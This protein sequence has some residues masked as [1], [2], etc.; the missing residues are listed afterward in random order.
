MEIIEYGGW[1]RNVRM[2]N[3]KIEL[4]ATLD[5][6]PRI[7][8]LAV[9]GGPNVFKQY[10]DQMGKAGEAAWQ[11]RGGHRLWFAPEDPVA[12]YFPDNGPVQVEELPRGI[13]LRP[14]PE[15]ANGIQKEIDITLDKKRPRVRL[16][17]R[18]IN[19]GQNPVKLAPWALTVMAPG[20][21]MILGLPPR[22]SH[23]KDLLPNQ[24]ITLWPYTDLGDARLKCGTRAILLRQD[25]AATKPE[26]FGILTPEGW[27]AYAVAGC[28]FV[29]RFPCK[30]RKAYPDMGCNAEFFTNADMLEVESLGPLVNLKPGRK[31]EH[32]EDWS[33]FAG[34][35]AI[36]TEAA[37]DQY[38]RPLVEPQA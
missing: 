35:P 2:A 13:R 15:T 9:P 21:T 12:T 16:R 29:K 1:K 30:P 28:L 34:V 6:G 32:V 8:H 24:T 27:A 3:P 23:P 5:C 20:G 22:G 36:E 25:T 38:V 37:V 17:H 10:A 18:L 33:L 11:I 26:K 7:I 14:A 31:V 19:I 4:V